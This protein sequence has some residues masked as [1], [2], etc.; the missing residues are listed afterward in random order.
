[1]ELKKAY[2]NWQINNPDEE[3]IIQRKRTIKES[4]RKFY[5][6]KLIAHKNKK[7]LGLDK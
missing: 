7:R 1:M 3:H 2:K 5:Q 6:K 4:T